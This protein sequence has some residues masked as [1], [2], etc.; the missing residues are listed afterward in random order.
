MA[1]ATRQYDSKKYQSLTRV[2]TASSI[3]HYIPSVPSSASH[4]RTP[5]DSFPTI[6]EHFDAAVYPRSSFG[7]FDVHP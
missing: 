1:F 2:I 3:K 6:A 5:T 7:D 4:A